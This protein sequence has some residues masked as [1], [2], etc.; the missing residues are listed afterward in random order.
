MSG[1]CQA[2]RSIIGSDPVVITYSPVLPCFNRNSFYLTYVVLS[3]FVYAPLPFS[4]MFASL[5]RFPF[6]SRPM[7]TSNSSL[8]AFLIPWFKRPGVLPDFYA[9]VRIT[10]TTGISTKNKSPSLSVTYKRYK[11]C[12][13]DPRASRRFP[14]W[15]V[16][17]LDENPARMSAS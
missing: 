1:H 10:S 15:S 11:E 3:V 12:T 2:L 5:T 14:L 8:L 4:L 9:S 16:H 6:V 17:P 13:F 7:R